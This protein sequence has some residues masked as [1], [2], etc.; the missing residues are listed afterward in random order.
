MEIASAEEFLD[1]DAECFALEVVLTGGSC[2]SLPVRFSVDHAGIDC[3]LELAL[4]E[5]LVG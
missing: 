3:A 1:I 2:A 5:A 4:V